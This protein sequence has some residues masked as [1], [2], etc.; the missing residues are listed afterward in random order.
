MSKK[1]YLVS[2]VLTGNRLTPLN[3][4]TGICVKFSVVFTT[5]KYTYITHYNTQIKIDVHKSAVLNLWNEDNQW[6]L[7]NCLVVREQ[8]P[9][10]VFF[11]DINTQ[12]DQFWQ[13]SI[14]IFSSGL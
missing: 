2:Q 7:V 1:A 9:L 3:D 4:A 14:S 11:K 5:L 8:R 6:S 10:F 12:T 13:F